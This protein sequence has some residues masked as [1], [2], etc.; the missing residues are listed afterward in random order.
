M[1]PKEDVVMIK[2]NDLLTNEEAFGFALVGCMVGPRPGRKKVDDLVT[3]WGVE[4]SFSFH[5]NGW[6][7]FKFN[8]AEDLESVLTKG[9]YNSFGYPWIIRKVPEYFTFSD[10]CFSSV[11]IWINL[12]KLP[13]K[14]WSKKVLSKIGSQL[15]NPIST[16]MVTETRMFNDCAR[17]L[18][19]VDLN[20]PIV[21]KVSLSMPNGRIW[22]QPVEYEIRPVVCGKCKAVGHVEEKCKRSQLSIPTRGRSLGRRGMSK[23]P[24]VMRPDEREKE[25]VDEDGVEAQGGH[26]TLMNKGA[27][28]STRMENLT[29]MVAFNN[30]LEATQEE[31]SDHST[32]LPKSI[33]GKELVM[34]TSMGELQ[35]SV[36]NT[37]PNKSRPKIIDDSLSSSA[38]TLGGL[39]DEKRSCIPWLFM[40][41]NVS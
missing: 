8:N 31:G 36:M 14:C 12:R 41:N 23:N 26:E 5:P 30:M 40:K 2:E 4:C 22:D 3:S 28:T 37:V 15:R 18:V 35:K 7:V 13:K 21:E 38:N 1:L 32:S 6:I 10:T 27:Y 39:F 16:D 9:P 29:S 11:P 17:I 24:N 25:K 19:E 34:H 33:E 20:E